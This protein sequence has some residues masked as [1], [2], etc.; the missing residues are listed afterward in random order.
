[1]TLRTTLVR[2]V[3]VASLLT[4]GFASTGCSSTLSDA[5]TI[6][7]THIRRDDFKN[8]LDEIGNNADLMTFFESQG[9]PFKRSDNDQRVDTQLASS[10]MLLRVQQAVIDREFEARHLKV[11]DAMREQA[12]TQA[13]AAFPRT[14]TSKNSSQTS[15][16]Q[17][18]KSFQNA[19][20]ERRARQIALMDSLPATPPQI[21]VEQARQVYEQNKDQLF[22]CA[23]AKTVAH[24]VVATVDEARDVLSQLEGGADFSTVAAQRSTEAATKN[25]GG[26]ISNPQAAPGCYVPGGSPQLDDAVNGATAGK[27]AGPV[28]T[29]SGYEVILVTPFTPPSFDEI[30]DQLM[31]SLQQQASQQSADNNRAAALNTLVTQRLR[32]ADVHVDPRYG[33]WVVDSQGPRVEPPSSPSVRGT[34][35]KPSTATTVANPLLGTSG[36]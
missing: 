21:T 2:F 33:K 14:P 31:A 27:P 24:I 17:F 13:E 9:L 5:A 8:E 3:A 23:S 7:G 35:T 1:M 11:T 30:R 34:R 36:G 4:V 18:S 15:F 20:I 10:W 12:K 28:L 16:E 32:R 26:V 22:P 25:D 19:E 29:Q 6:D